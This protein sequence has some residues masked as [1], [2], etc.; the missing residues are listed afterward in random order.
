MLGH[1]F[2][3][4]SA[5]DRANGCTYDGAY[6]SGS[7]R[8]RRRTGSDTTYRCA[9][10]NSNRVRT[11]G[12]SNRVKIC[13]NLCCGAIFAVIVHVILRCTVEHVKRLVHLSE[14]AD[15]THKL[16]LTWLA[17]KVARSSHANDVIVPLMWSMR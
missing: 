7:D 8:A 1:R 10:S 14:L 16:L 11:R 5:R 17:G 13:R 9:K 6:R 2:A 12:A 15:E 3:A 4:E